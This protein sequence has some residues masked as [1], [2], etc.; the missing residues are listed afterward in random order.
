MSLTFPPTSGAKKV[1]IPFLWSPK[2]TASNAKENKS[3][4]SLHFWKALTSILFPCSSP[5]NLRSHLYKLKC[6]KKKKSSFLVHIC[7]SLLSPFKLTG[8]KG[9]PKLLFVLRDSLQNL[10]LQKHKT[11]F[12]VT[13]RGTCFLIQAFWN[14]EGKF[15]SLLRNGCYSHWK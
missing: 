10:Y 2:L 11:G 12:L 13:W 14:R 6:L 7:R 8:T 3:R 9:L 5:S 15:L 4:N 1:A